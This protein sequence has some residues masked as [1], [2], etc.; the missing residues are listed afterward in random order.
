MKSKLLLLLGAALCC[1]SITV[2]PTFAQGL[3]FT[4]NRYNVGRHPCCVVAADVNG[5]GKVDLVSA[6][7]SANSLMV[8]TNNGSGDFGSNITLNVGSGPVWVAAA[9]LNNDGRLDFGQRE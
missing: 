9:D 4:T 1:L 8:L 2:D 7:N 3:T 6:N 5:D